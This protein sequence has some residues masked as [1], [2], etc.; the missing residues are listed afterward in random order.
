MSVPDERPTI[1]AT[2][3]GPYLV[4]AGV[5]VVRRRIERSA[6]GQA[7][8]WETTE[9]LDTDGVVALCRC[10]HSANK[11]FC[12]GSHR[13][14]EFDGTCTA[15]PTTYDDRAKEIPGEGITVRDVRGLCVHAGFCTNRLTHVWKMTRKGDVA[16]AGARAAVIGMIERCPSGALTYRVDPAGPDI[17]PDLPTQVAV[18]NEGPL[19][20]TGGVAVV[21]PDGTQYEVRNR[22]A[23]CRCG[24]SRTKPFCDGTHYDVGFADPAPETAAPADGEAAVS[25]G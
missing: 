5:P 18:V 20:V 2:P 8:T 11:P 12:D 4:R 17:E 3:D 10:G 15:D 13:R 24:H 1:S 25:A 6:D 16:E 21:G 14:E 23:L 7:L 22:V 19:Y 9:R